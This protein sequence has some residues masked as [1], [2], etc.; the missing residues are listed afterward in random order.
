MD[1]HNKGGD[2]ECKKENKEESKEDR[3]SEV[4]EEVEERNS[5]EQR[6]KD[7]AN[8]GSK[9]EAQEDSNGEAEVVAPIASSRIAKE[10][11]EVSP[12]SNF[13]L[14]DRCQKKCKYFNS[15]SILCSWTE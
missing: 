3:S 5:E 4:D 13:L 9:C 8:I 12:S 14:Q 6:D 11:K 7:E 15:Y 10:K 1:T 2:K